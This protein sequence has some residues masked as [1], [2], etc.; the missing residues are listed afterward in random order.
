MV[1]HFLI[2]IIAKW[3]VGGYTNTLYV[4]ALVE[5]RDAVR[6]KRKLR[7]RKGFEYWTLKQ[8]YFIIM[9]GVRVQ[10]K[11]DDTDT[12]DL[13][14]LNEGIYSDLDVVLDHV[15][16]DAKSFPSDADIDE[17][18]KSSLLAKVMAMGQLLWFAANVIS[19]LSGGLSVS[20]AEV[21][22]ISNVLLSTLAYAAWFSKPYDVTKSM[23]ITLDDDLRERAEHYYGS[24]IKESSHEH[25]W[26]VVAVLQTEPAIA[27]V[28]TLA[29]LGVAGMHVAAWNYSFPSFAELWIWRSCSL[30]LFA[31]PLL[32]IGP[33]LIV[34]KVERQEGLLLMV[35]LLTSL[36]VLSRLALM[37]LALIVFRAA[38]AS[39]YEKVKWTSYLGHIGS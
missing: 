9:G 34:D 30:A 37:I 36:F 18:N 22:T 16:L 32:M 1:V 3:F 24:V 19:R 12:T 21:E 26:N 31:F 4:S 20:L 28:M 14:N 38:P 2:D 29:F 39:I 10:R 35:V 11:D 7:N 25:R 13:K 33:L 15:P 27:F 17:R 5:L 6:L 23:T 8:S